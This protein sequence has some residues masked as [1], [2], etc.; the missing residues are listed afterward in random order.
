MFGTRIVALALRC[1]REPFRQ[2]WSEDVLQTYRDGCVSTSRTH[3]RI[4]GSVH[5][6]AELVDLLKAA[7]RSRFGAPIRITGGA[8][9]YQPQ[10]KDQRV[11][12]LF[13][14][15]WNAWRRLVREPRAALGSVL[16]LALAIGVTSAVFTVVDAFIVRPAPF[17]DP[18]TLAKLQ[19]MKGV[20]YG[21]MDFAAV[22]AWRDSGVFSVSAGI[23]V[24]SI[25]PLS[26]DFLAQLSRPRVA[27]A[28]ATSFAGLA[29]F[30]T[31][32]GLYGVLAYVVSR[33]RREFEIRAALGAAPMALRRSVL[34]DGMRVSVAGIALGVAAGWGLSRWLASIQF[35]VTFFDP[36]TWSVV[37]GAVLVIT[38][39]SSWRPATE[40]MRV[41]PSEILREP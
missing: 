28:V 6:I 2:H 8:P 12:T 18:G 20:E 7:W 32:A 30:A 41:D 15:F 37:I 21:R 16:L 34:A 38:L 10:P 11:N 17:R 27:A 19:V 26:K 33:R 31:A 13:Q 4:A 40:A 24:K 29:L 1:C 9:L 3:G 5:A 23:I 25:E 35:G 14:D 22:R 39:L 36:L